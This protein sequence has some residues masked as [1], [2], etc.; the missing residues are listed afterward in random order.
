[1]VR[2]LRPELLDPGIVKAINA[3]KS[4]PPSDRPTLIIDI[5]FRLAPSAL[6]S[7]IFAVLSLLMKYSLHAVCSEKRISHARRLKGVRFENG[8]HASLMKTAIPI[9]WD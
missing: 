7:G 3:A 5:F 4:D 6:L 9:Y 8:A 1:S 2:S